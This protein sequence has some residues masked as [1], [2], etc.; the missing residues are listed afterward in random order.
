MPFKPI[1]PLLPDLPV[2][3]API[4][5]RVEGCGVH[6]ARPELGIAATGDQQGSLEHLQMLGHRLEADVERLG[7]LVDR[8]LANQLR[9]ASAAKVVLSGSSAMCGHVFDGVSDQ[10]A[11]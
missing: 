2:S 7:Q 9:S 4:D 11:G 5:R 6:P 8:R 1:E 3:G 10:R